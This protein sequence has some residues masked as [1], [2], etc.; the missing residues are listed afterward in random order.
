MA[1]YIDLISDNVKKHSAAGAA[2]AQVLT[3]KSQLEKDQGLA[4]EAATAAYNSDTTL[5][6]AVALQPQGVRDPS[7]GVVYQVIGGVLHTIVPVDATE[8]DVPDGPLPSPSPAVSVSHI[9]KHYPF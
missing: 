9:R 7:T 2:D 1:K 8:L 5:T 6:I 3:D 4:E